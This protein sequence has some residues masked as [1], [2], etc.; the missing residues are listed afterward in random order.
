MSQ[1][2]L[3]H[4]VCDVHGDRRAREIRFSLENRT[5]GFDACGECEDEFLGDFE[6][7]MKLATVQRPKPAA[8]PAK[9]RG[10]VYPPRA[11]PKLVRDWAAANGVECSARGRIPRAVEDQY[12]AAQ[13]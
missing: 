7:W 9:R 2:T 3:T 13:G 8:T 10:Y 1:Q 5:F 6:P 11:V 4:R 12:L